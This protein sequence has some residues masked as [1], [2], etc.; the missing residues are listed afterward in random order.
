MQRIPE[1]L[2]K[3]FVQQ[4]HRRRKLCL[5]NEMGSIDWRVR[6]EKTKIA[7]TLCLCFRS[8]S[9][10]RFA[11]SFGHAGSKEWFP[12][13]SNLGQTTLGA[14]LCGRGYRC[15]LWDAGSVRSRQPLG[16]LRSL[17]LLVAHERSLAVPGHL[18]QSF[19]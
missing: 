16:L 19:L 2:G 5:G 6:L 7:G 10:L 3:S 14:W 11:E 17:G 1:G 8:L 9:V 12:Q 13:F 18:Y 15:L 4:R